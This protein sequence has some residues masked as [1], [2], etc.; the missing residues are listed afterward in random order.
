MDLRK[1]DSK[2][3]HLLATF[4][5]CITLIFSGCSVIARPALKGA[6]NLISPAFPDIVSS[7]M[8]G[9]NTAYGQGMYGPPGLLTLAG[10]FSEVSPDN[11]TLAWSCS[12]LSVATAAYNEMFRPVYAR[13][14]AWQGYRFGMRSLMTH[15]KFREA[16][17]SGMPVEKAVNL[18]PKKYVEG[19]TW[20]AMSL[21]FHMMMNIDDVLTITYAPEVNNMIK[22]AIELDGTYFHGMPYALDAV[23][24]AMASQMVLGCGLGPAQESYS[25]S[26]EISGGK[27][28]LVDALYAQFY[29]IALRDHELFHKL[30]NDVLKAPDDI[31]EYEGF[32]LT[33]L[34]KGRAKWLLEHEDQIFEDMGIVK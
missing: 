34:A 30:L 29:A 15:R 31:L 5:V 22:R 19:L 27:L 4:L 6:A 7:G 9:V 8:A 12:Q 10:I 3:I 26:K 28:I 33:T 20:T 25:K 17:E 16:V 32:Y 24:N 2:A 18:L 13:D 11:Y 14:L 21:A 1:K 23:F